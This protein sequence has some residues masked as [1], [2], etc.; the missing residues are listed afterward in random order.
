M[1]AGVPEG[2]VVGLLLAALRAKQLDGEITTR[3]QAEQWVARQRE[4]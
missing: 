3:G 2:K 1:T 4:A